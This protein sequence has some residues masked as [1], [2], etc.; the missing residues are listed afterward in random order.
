LSGDAPEA[1]GLS[2]RDLLMEMR[3]DIRGVVPA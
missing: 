2:Q 1:T 3:E